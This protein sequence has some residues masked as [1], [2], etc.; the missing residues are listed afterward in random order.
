[1]SKKHIAVYGTL[2]RGHY[3]FR[4]GQKFLFEARVPGYQLY[5]LGVYPCVIPGDE[6]EEVT[7]EVMEVDENTYNSIT[8]MEVGAGYKPVTITITNNEVAYECTIYEYTFKPTRGTRIP[9][10]NYQPVFI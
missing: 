6:T 5:D 2:K 8:R 9:D 7:V 4:S 3:N 10:G 1:M